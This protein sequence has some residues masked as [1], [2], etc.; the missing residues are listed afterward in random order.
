M[1]IDD[2]SALPGLLALAF[3]GVISVA[4]AY[5]LT[6]MVKNFAL[7]KGLCDLGGGRKVHTSPIPRIGGLGIFG[8]FAV[9]IGCLW[10]LTSI[11]PSTRWAFTMPPQPIIV[12]ALVMCA[13]GLA[14]DLLNLSAWEK[15][16]SQLLMATLVVLGGFR[17][18]PRFLPLDSLPFAA[19]FVLVPLTV[20]WILAV[21]NAVNLIDGLDGLAAGITFLAIGSLTAAMA[22]LGFASN[23]GFA[24]VFLGALSGFLVFNYHPAKIFMGDSGSL[25]LGF[26]LAT[27]SLP[28]TEHPSSMLAFLIPVVALGIPIL[29]TTIAFCRRVLAGQSPFAADREHIHH[30]LGARLN[31]SHRDTVLFLYATAGVLGFCAVALAAGS[32]WVA[33]LSLTFA[34]FLGVFFVVRLGYFS[35]RPLFHQTRQKLGLAWMGRKQRPTSLESA[36][37]TAGQRLEPLR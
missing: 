24:V 20:L 23:L 33:L 10:A 9:G 21:I 30:R 15:L 18:N 16:V 26:I 17:F 28:V 3:S 32:L 1:V 22:L 2:Q 25:F 6:R 4:A 31:L 11:F 14:D 37:P 27:Y 7:S 29:D 8:G 36:S 13:F 5:L 12:G 19:D 35:P 34:A